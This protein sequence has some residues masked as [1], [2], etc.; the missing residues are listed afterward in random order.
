MEGSST[1]FDFAFDE[2]QAAWPGPSSDTHMQPY[3]ATE[4][5][6]Q[7]PLESLVLSEPEQTPLHLSSVHA[8]MRQYIAGPST[9]DIGRA[10]DPTTT[11]VD[12]GNEEAGSDSLNNAFATDYM[13]D[14]VGAGPIDPQGDS[15][16]HLQ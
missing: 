8:N 10:I 9:K 2:S 13:L 4:W 15:H 5:G 1:F 3:H 16:R 12:G 6:W 11:L 7:E 14:P